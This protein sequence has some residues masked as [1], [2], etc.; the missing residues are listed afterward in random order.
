MKLPGYY[1]SGEFAKKAHVSVRTI[2]FYD[3]QNVLKPSFISESGARFYSDADF[4][5]LQQ[6]LLLKYLGFSLEDIKNMTIGDSDSAILLNSL[7]LQLKLIQDKIEQMQ[8]VEKAIRDTTT[9]IEQN[10]S[11]DW[12][13]MLDLIHLTGMENSLKSQY[14]NA[15]NISARIKLHELYSVNKQGWFPWIFEKCNIT[16]LAAQN[17]F[18]N[19]LELGCGSGSLWQQNKENIP[20]N[21]NLVLT[22][23]SHGMLRDTQRSLKELGN[24]VKFKAFDCASIPYPDNSFDIVIANHV[25]F[26]VNDI[27]AVCM[28]AAR[29]L[30]PQGHFICS[31]YSSNHMKEISALASE[32]DN[33]IVLSADKLYEKFGLD[34]GS[35]ILSGHFSQ[36]EKHIYEDRLI[37]DK[38]EPI[39]EYILSCHGN[40]SQYII[41][42]YKDFREFMTRKTARGLEITKEAGLFICTK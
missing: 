25:L 34:N 27:D 19:V 9:A 40:Q 11:V 12:S 23:I 35:D 3:K 41:D 36:I 2:R 28:E 17:S 21:C 30:K 5:R 38:P 6:V 24:R 18:I 33:R 37:V 26:Y 13:K 31:T 7:H 14:Q 42:R 39:I 15:G 32:F 29:V 4:A 22:D 8:L 20:S 16:K 10:N 1:T